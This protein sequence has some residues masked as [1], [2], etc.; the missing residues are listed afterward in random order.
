MMVGRFAGF[1]RRRGL[2]V[3]AGKSKVIVLNR[4]EGLQ[5]EVHGD[6]I[7]LQH[8]SKF[9]YLGCVLDDSGIDCAEYNR[10]VASRKR[11]AGDIRSLVNASNL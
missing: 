4:E 6:G 3:N 1:C 5:C 7:R 8:V 10:K 2:K 11:V 9:K